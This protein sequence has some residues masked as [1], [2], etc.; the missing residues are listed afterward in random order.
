MVHSKQ[1]QTYFECEGGHILD[2]KPGNLQVQIVYSNKV[3]QSFF[4]CL[5]YPFPILY[6]LYFPVRGEILIS[7]LSPLFAA[8]SS[9]EIG[10][11]REE[12]INGLSVQMFPGAD[13]QFLQRCETVV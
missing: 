9:P 11:C 13:L 4:L 1:L 8:S 12:D 10:T 3:F 6:S 2:N 5:T 7:G